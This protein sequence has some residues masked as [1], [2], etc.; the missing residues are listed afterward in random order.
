MLAIAVPMLAQFPGAVGIID[1]A[2]QV[3][4]MN[5]AGHGLG[6]FLQ[7]DVA[8]A[9]ALRAQRRPGYLR[10]QVVEADRKQTGM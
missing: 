8:T 2:G 1:G 9:Q 7:Q 10:L 4:A 3:T 6:K 5:E